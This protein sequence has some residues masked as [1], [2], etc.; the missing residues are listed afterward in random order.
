M[1]FQIETMLLTE[2]SQKATASPKRT[3]S[4]QQ[5]CIRNYIFFLVEMLCEP[6][7]YDL[8]KPREDDLDHALLV[9]PGKTPSHV[10]TQI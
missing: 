9:N 1:K 8:C 7:L 10:R 2:K 6:V 3:L 5:L 4:L